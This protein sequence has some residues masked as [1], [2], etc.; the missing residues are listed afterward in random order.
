MSSPV[1]KKVPNN[2]FTQVIE[3]ANKYA[4]IHNIPNKEQRVLISKIESDFN[5]AEA[6]A[7]S[8]AKDN[9]I[10]YRNIKG[11]S[12][13]YIGLGKIVDKDDEWYAVQISSDK[14]SLSI[15][16]CKCISQHQAS[17]EAHRIAEQKHMLF[18]PSAIA[19]LQRQ[20]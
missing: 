5:V 10:D 1:A 14:V 2:S 19:H 18:V 8:F 12:L 9:N 3:V 6:A 20:S 15:S 7:R 16:S 13:S 4:A 11:V 17:A